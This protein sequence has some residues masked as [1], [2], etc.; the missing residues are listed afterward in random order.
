MAIITSSDLK[1]HL[2]ISDATD[3]TSLGVAVAA[4][5]AAV[6]RWCGRSFD[7]TTTASASARVYRPATPTLTVTDD[8]WTT[9]ALVVKLDEGDD[10]TYEST[11]TLNTDYIVEPLNGLEAGASV[12]YRRI[13]ATSWLFSTSHT[14][15]NVQVTA[16]WGWASIPDDVKLAAL[17]LGARIWKR[18]NSPEG[19][20]GGFQDFG[21]VRITSRQDPD[22]VNL[23]ADYRRSETSLYT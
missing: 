3:D 14:I 18:K 13:L 4:A 21:A 23:L 2:K 5:N 1:T 15:P 22:V 9:T 19:V 6:V 17:I 20:L 10:G 7:T 16:A 8:F 12:P 11:L